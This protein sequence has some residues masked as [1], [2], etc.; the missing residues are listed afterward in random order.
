MELSQRQQKILAEIRQ[1][2]EVGVDALAELYQVSSQTIRR[3]IN[4]LCDRG[5]A[6]RTHGGARLVH[7]VS[8]V[9]YGQRRELAKDAKQIIGALAAGLIPENSSLMLNIGTTTEQ[10]AKALF[11]HNNLL[12]ISNNINVINVLTGAPNKSLVL[13]GGSVRQSDGAIIGDAAV[14]FIANFKVDFAIVGCS[15]IDEDGS[16]L[17]FDASEVSVAK[18]I[19]QNARTK[20]LVGD[21]M[22]FQKAAPFRISHVADMDYFIT[23]RAPPD[24]FQRVA[25]EADT[26]IITP[27]TAAN[28]QVTIVAND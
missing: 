9:S 13:A 18:A 27:E 3:D 1:S 21:Y 5:L 6:A 11:N 25:A 8:N 15:S 2:N 10:V 20:I 12:V 16:M 4:I 28:E 7:S 17:D 23:D 22:K 26:K 24:T 19:L 14:A